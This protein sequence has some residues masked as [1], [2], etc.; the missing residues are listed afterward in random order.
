MMP[1]SFFYIFIVGLVIGSFL[2]SYTYRWPRGYSAVKGRSLCPH[3]KRKIAWFDN[4]PVLSYVFLRGKCRFCRKKISIRY[5]LIELG[6]ALIFLI[7][8]YFFNLCRYN[9]QNNF[10]QNNAII[11]ELQ[12]A[13]GFWALPYLL[14]FASFLIAIFVIDLEEQLIPDDLVFYLILLAVFAVFLKN[15]SPFPYLLSGFGASFFFLF[16]HLITKGRGMGLGDVKLV[17]PLSVF[18]GMPLFVI[19]LSVSFIVGAIVGIFLISLGRA[20]FGKPVPFGPFLILGFFLTLFWGN[21]FSE[22]FS[23]LG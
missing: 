18:L 2:T 12:K 6:T 8:F 16:L 3:C 14:L 9:L 5:P 11:C 17:V 19:F 1:L 4:I 22:F 21:I 23:L 20:S 15:T 13:L 10:Y 7:N